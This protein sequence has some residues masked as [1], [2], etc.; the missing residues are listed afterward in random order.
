MTVIWMSSGKQRQ[1][2]GACC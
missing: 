2:P 1:A